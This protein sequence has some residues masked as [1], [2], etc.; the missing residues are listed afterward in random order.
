MKGLLVKDFRI[1]MMQ[2]KFFA[3]LLLCGVIFSFQAEAEMVIAYLS[4]GFAYFVNSTISYDEFDNG[5]PFLMTL[6]V[7]RKQYAL[8]KYIFGFLTSGFGWL[9]GIGIAVIA[10][11]MKE[12]AT[13]FGEWILP[14]GCMLLIAFLFLAVCIPIQ[15]KFG[16]ENARLIQFGALVIITAL[17]FLMDKL[18]TA[19]GISF[20][21]V[22]DK[23]LLNNT[24]LLAGVLLGITSLLLCI[25]MAVSC[26][27]MQRKEF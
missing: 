2:K 5:M 21:T 7:T 1:L 8:E 24:A 3:V 26:R 12:A 4:F 13:P 16:A 18:L 22:I 23:S 14:V 10:R 11:E 25:S 17:I 6:P 9:I 19:G 27:I 15:L 20:E